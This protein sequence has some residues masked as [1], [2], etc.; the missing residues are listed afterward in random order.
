MRPQELWTRSLT[1]S[2]LQTVVVSAGVAD[3]V[4]RRE[5]L[6]VAMF[7]HVLLVDLQDVVVDIHD[8]ERDGNP[9]RPE[10]LELKG[11]HR[12][13]GVLDQDLIDGKVYLFP[14][15]EITLSQVSTQ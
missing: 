14:G 1:E 5:R 2:R 12:A 3:A 7:V 8:C 6:Q 9:V 15:N 11:G 4:A 13:K 10:R